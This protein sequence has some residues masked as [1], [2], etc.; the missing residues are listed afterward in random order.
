MQIARNSTTE[1]KQWIAT[2]EQLPAKHFLEVEEELF[3]DLDD[4]D[5][6]VRRIEE[7]LSVE[8]LIKEVMGYS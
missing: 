6:R 7:E 5:E 1:L 2:V 8:A 4:D 3:T